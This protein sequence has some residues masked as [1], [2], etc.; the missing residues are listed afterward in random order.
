M[1]AL[2]NLPENDY[3]AALMSLASQLLERRA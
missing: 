1:D 3:R 2:G